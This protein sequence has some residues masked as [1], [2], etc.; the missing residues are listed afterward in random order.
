MNRIHC[1]VCDNV[2]H[3]ATLI[4]IRGTVRSVKVENVDI[5]LDCLITAL[6]KEARKRTTA[7]ASKKKPAKRATR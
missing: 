6:K 2:A 4:N 3:K 7:P 1:D 5:C